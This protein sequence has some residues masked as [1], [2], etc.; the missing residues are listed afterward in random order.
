[1]TAQRDLTPSPPGKDSLVGDV[2]L[3]HQRN[4]DT[5]VKDYHHS[6]PTAVE[7][8]EDHIIVDLGGSGSNENA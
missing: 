8:T 4:R 6:T 7:Q 2:G 5:G 1:M 3:N